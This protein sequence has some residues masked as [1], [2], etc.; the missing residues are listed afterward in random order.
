MISSKCDVVALDVRKAG[1]TFALGAVHR[2]SRRRDEEG[3]RSGGDGSRSLC[4]VIFTV[5]LTLN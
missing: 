5:Q 1:V 2:L 3:D 4:D